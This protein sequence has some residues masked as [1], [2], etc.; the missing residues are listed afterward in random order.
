MTASSRASSGMSNSWA[1]SN[2]TRMG[3]GPRRIADPRKGMALD[4]PRGAPMRVL[5]IN[6]GSSSLKYA[7]FDVERESRAGETEVARGSVDRIGST[8]PDHAAAV[9][10]LLDEIA[11][12]DGPSRRRWGIASCTA[13]RST[14]PPRAWTARC[15]NR[16]EA[17]PVRA[18]APS[19]RD[20]RHRGRGAE[21]ARL[22]PGGV[23]RHR[24]SPD[25]LGRRPALRAA[26]ARRPGGT[27]S[28]WL[29]WPVV[30]V[31]RRRGGRGD[32]WSRGARAPGQR[33]E[34]G[35][36]ARRPVGRHHHGVLADRRPGDG[37]PARRRR[38]GA[39]RPLA[40]VGERRAGPRQPR[41]PPVR[42]PRRQRD[43]LRRARAARPARTRSAC[44]PR[45]RRL[46][47]ERGKWVGAM[48]AAAGGLDT[49]VFTGG[50]GEHAPALRLES[51][52]ASSTSACASTTRETRAPTR[53]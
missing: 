52:A 18:A 2:C 20:R 14:R 35:G 31:C 8:V 29:S 32:P 22:P 23:L 1:I 47:V 51:P 38:P 11:R 28:L 3:Q 6:C 46:H 45:A 36:R 4:S 15:S 13:G 17:H 37:H 34:H 7:L 41:Q 25:A 26:R 49:L 39:A 53:L 19:A 48:A 40:P 50:I 12:R 21:V 10:A 24:V 9:H 16:C 43:H 30:R 44:R 33:G 42:T 5:S 27:P